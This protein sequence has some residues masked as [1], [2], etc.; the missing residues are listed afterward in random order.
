MVVGGDLGLPRRWFSLR[1]CVADPLPNIRSLVVR[2]VEL[3][4]VCWGVPGDGLV[5]VRFAA[6]LEP[7][8][9][10]VTSGSQRRHA[11][12]EAAS[13][14]MRATWRIQRS[15]VKLLWLCALLKP[16]DANI[17]EISKDKNALSRVSRS[18]LRTRRNPVTT[19]LHGSLTLLTI[20]YYND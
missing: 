6:F 19:P 15:S 13:G 2:C 14:D 3:R 10:F 16:A 8:A 20:N 17:V 9:P 5:L 11:T 18:Q 1:C 4:F 7:A 12:L